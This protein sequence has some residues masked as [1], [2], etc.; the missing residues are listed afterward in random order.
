MRSISLVLAASAA[1]LSSTNAFGAPVP[2]CAADN[3]A[4]AV[5]PDYTK[6][7]RPAK[8]DRSQ[9]P[10]CTIFKNENPASFKAFVQSSFVYLNKHPEVPRILTIACFNE[11]S[12]GHYLLPDNRFGY[13]MLDAL[14]EALGKEGN[15]EKHG[16]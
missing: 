5:T 4:V 12:E 3:T 6:T 2:V 7:K 11:W 13:G 16:K 14:G 10:G 1:L 15:H 9:W 8:A